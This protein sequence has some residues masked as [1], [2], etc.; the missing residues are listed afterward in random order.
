LGMVWV[1][2]MLA[3]ALASFTIRTS[4]NGSLS[5]IHI[6]SFWT[7]IQ[8]PIIFWS[9]RTHNVLR[10]RSSVRGMVFGALLIAGFFTF[11]FNRLL[12]RWLFA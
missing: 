2:M 6:L 10:H 4:S 3:T 7:V 9:A 12:G 5:I 1:L 11:P 8:V